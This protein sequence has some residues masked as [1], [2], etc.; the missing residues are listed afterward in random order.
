M[1]NSKLPEKITNN[2]AARLTSSKFDN[3]D[4]LKII[5]SLNFSKAHGHDG[6]S[7]KMMTMCDELLVQPLLIIF[8]GCIDTG[9]YPDTWKKSNIVP[10]HKKGD[11][12]SLFSVAHDV[13]QSTNELNDGREKI[14]NCVYQ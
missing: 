6:N 2:S 8:R 1:N 9:V 3:S 14:S 11:D 12:T 10:V 5:R 7:V 4:I 13:M